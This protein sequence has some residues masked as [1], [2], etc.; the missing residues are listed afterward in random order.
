MISPIATTAPTRY[1]S[2]PVEVASTSFRPA[3]GAKKIK[4]GTTLTLVSRPR[5]DQ[6][7]Y[8]PHFDFF[9]AVRAAFSAVLAH[10]FF[11]YSLL[12]V[13][14]APPASLPGRTP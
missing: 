7:W 13:R 14:R 3:P 2:L 4:V 12:P 6:S 11:L 10:L 8:N 9:D 1:G 5:P